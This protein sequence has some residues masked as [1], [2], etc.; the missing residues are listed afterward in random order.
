[1]RMDCQTNRPL[2][3]AEA[4]TVVRELS[5]E[6]GPRAWVR[7]RPE[8]ALFWA[9][10]AG[11]IVARCPEQTGDL[12]TSLFATLLEDGMALPATGRRRQASRYHRP[13]RPRV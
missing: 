2:S 4:K 8:S 11:W 6:F 12:A 1:M 7:R 5:G 9:F 13:R 10:A 3:V